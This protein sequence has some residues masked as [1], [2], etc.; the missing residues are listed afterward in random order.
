MIFTKTEFVYI[1]KIVFTTI[2]LCVFDR[3]LAALVPSMTVWPV[4]HNAGLAAII[5]L[6]IGLAR[7]EE[8]SVKEGK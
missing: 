6:V 1:F 5:V 4:E 7:L 2:L 3:F 8:K